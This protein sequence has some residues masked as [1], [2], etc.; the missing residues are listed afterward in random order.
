MESPLQ[1]VGKLRMRINAH[2]PGA[3]APYECRVGIIAPPSFRVVHHFLSIAAAS[4]M[5]RAAKTSEMMPRN[6]CSARIRISPASARTAP[7]MVES[8]ITTSFDRLSPITLTTLHVK[9]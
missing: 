6:I 7:V 2:R 9:Q 4:P 1:F 8:R 5:K 3:Y